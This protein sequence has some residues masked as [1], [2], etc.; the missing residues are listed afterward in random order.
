MNQRLIAASATAALAACVLFAAGPSG[1]EPTENGSAGQWIHIVFGL[2]G[3]AADWSGSITAEQATLVELLP[4]GF[5]AR[6]RFSAANRSWQCTTELRRGR[7]ANSFAEPYR[8]LF[9]RLADVRPTSTLR[10]KTKQ[11]Q[12]VVPVA[13]LTY[14]TRWLFAD[15]RAFAQRVPAPRAIAGK[16]GTHDDFPSAVTDRNG[17]T[18]VAWIR[19]DEQN[20]RDELLVANLA[21]P[22]QAPEAVPAGRYVSSAQLTVDERGILTLFWCEWDGDDWDIYRSRRQDGRWSK[23]EAIVNDKGNDIFLQVDRGPD[24][25][26]WLVWQAYRPG[27]P[28]SQIFCLR[29]HGGELAGPVAVTAGPGNKWEPAVDVAPDGTAWIAYD[30]YERG[31]YDVFLVAVRADGGKLV[32]DQP[33]P[34]ATTADFEAHAA[35]DAQDERFV[36]VAYDAAGPNWGKDYARYSTRRNG[37]YAEPLHASRRIE[38]RA[39]DPRR[40]QL[41]QPAAPLPQLRNPRMPARIAH[42]Y[43]EEVIRFY[44]L[45]QLARDSA[46]RL[47]VLYRLNRQGYAGHP[48]KGAVWELCAA[49]MLDGRWIAPLIFPHSRGR[50]EQKAA[51]ARSP[52]G[53]V[54]AWA[55]GHHHVDR[56]YRLFWTTLPE[57]AGQQH[58]TLQPATAGNAPLQVETPVRSWHIERNGQRLEVV[59]GD[60]HRHTEISLCTPTVDGSLTETYRYAIDAAKLDF[61]A[62]TDH[63]RDTDPYPWWL[64]QKAADYFYHPGYFV[65]IYAYERSNAIVNGGHRN[66]FF[67]D[68]NWPVLRSDAHYAWAKLPRPDTRPNVS[69]YPRLRGRWA[70]T[71][72]HTPGFNRREQRGTWTYHDPQVEPVAEIFQAY[73]RDYE[74]PGRGVPEEASLWY[75][76]G[77]GHRLGFIASSDHHSTHLSYACVWAAARTRE[78]IFEGIR[79]RHTYGAMDKILLEVRLGDALMGDKLRVGAVGQIPTLRIRV[80]GTAP[81]EELQ[82]VRSSRV[83]ATLQPGTTDVSVTYKDEDYPGGKCYYYVR[84]RQT[85]G[86]VAWGSA[87]WLAP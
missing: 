23:P 57:L 44:E 19:F 87:I 73:R 1:K 84:V 7:S 42:S 37:R 8:G 17:N 32:V 28:E 60:L 52:A 50:Q 30:S 43:Q 31:N 15:G 40:G 20:L 25:A 9:V 78:A 75:A 69:L 6:D 79:S 66:V 24:G 72:A 3:K 12:F 82:I 48:R 11:G 59:F 61:L 36:W 65:S 5:E 54:V 49:T 68:R 14:E 83:I 67:R 51:I 86:S 70:F 74:R 21:A 39:Y 56:P 53:T 29:L 64:T 38:L 33:V 18:W 4:W 41:W 77:R 76:L 62:V 22:G 58:W 2:D 46:G 81:I 16:T 55:S 13:E 45:P 27:R 80:R 71:I 85:D 26:N 10:L 35:V 63:T 34:I 47:W